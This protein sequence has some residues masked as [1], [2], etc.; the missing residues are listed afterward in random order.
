MGEGFMRRP[1][2]L[3]AVGSALVGP[4]VSTGVG[5]QLVPDEAKLVLEAHNLWRAHHQAGSL[6]W[7]PDLARYAQ[8]WAEVLVTRYPGRLVHSDDG[9]GALPEARELGYGGWGENLYWSS[10]VRWSDGVR[11]ARRDL[12]PSEV[13]DSWAGEVRWYDFATAACSAP[14]G[15][16]CGHFT[17]VVW[18]ETR[19]VGCGRAFGADSAQVWVCSYDPP[20]NWE[21]EYLGNVLPERGAEHKRSDPVGALTDPTPRAVSAA[22]KSC[23]VV[24]VTNRLQKGTGRSG[25]RRLLPP[26]ALRL[27]P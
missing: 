26:R 23:T 3:V 5:A 19:S 6:A 8:A 12:P 13:V 1:W 2:I 10:A 17:Q 21:G 9:G 20:G 24:A 22:E 18:K 7:S 14:S 11:E 4:A 27:C 15:E 16:G 25:D